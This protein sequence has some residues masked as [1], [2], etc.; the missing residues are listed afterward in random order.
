MTSQVVFHLCHLDIRHGG[1]L[2]GELRNLPENLRPFSE[3][4]NEAV[5]RLQVQCT[6]LQEEGDN[7]PKATAAIRTLGASFQKLEITV[8][9][10]GP[11]ERN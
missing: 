6:R 9:Y 10:Y 7:R 5:K 1:L 11:L 4:I 8:K 3:E 2:Q